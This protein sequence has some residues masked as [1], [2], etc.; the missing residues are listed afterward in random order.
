VRFRTILTHVAPGPGPQAAIDLACSV[1]RR[2][3]GLV[4]GLAVGLPQM[5]V[6]SEAGL[7][8]SGFAETL[9][10]DFETTFAAAAE[11]FTARAR[12]AQVGY[13]LRASR[14]PPTLSLID[15][16]SGADLT[17][18]GRIDPADAH[19]AFR[20]ALDDVLLHAAGPVLVATQ[21]PIDFV[22]VLVAW[23]KTPECARAITA[24]LP[25]LRFAARVD[26]LR[27]LEGHGSAAEDAAYADALDRLHRHDVQ[28]HPAIIPANGLR[29]AD[30][31]L[32][33]ASRRAVTLVVLGAY[34]HA[35]LREWVLGGVTHD[36]LHA[37]TAPA[38]LFAH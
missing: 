5:P 36:L 6:S 26:L 27:V 3:D 25:L 20:V 12:R 32:R 8:D 31:L 38:L 22:H 33:E 30:C 9:F 1:A 35:R 11:D 23:R 28:A 15:A 18:L 2:G 4:R 17:V 21:S 7:A 13:E 29:V 19:P 24:A 37:G 14:S 10:E 16:S 34:G